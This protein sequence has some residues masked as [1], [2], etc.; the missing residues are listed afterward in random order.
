MSDTEYNDPQRPTQDKSQW[1][2]LRIFVSGP[3]VRLV[4]AEDG[5]HEIVSDTGV[6]CLE[7]KK[8]GCL[9]APRKTQYRDEL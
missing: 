5:R 2:P 1:V 6:V 7:I 3:G 8:R 4:P 9:R